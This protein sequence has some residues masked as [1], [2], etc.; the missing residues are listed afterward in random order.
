MAFISPESPNVYSNLNF[1][2]DLKKSSGLLLLTPPATTDTSPINK[3]YLL[4]NNFKYYNEHLNKQ[5]FNS[6]LLNCSINLLKMLYPQVHF[7]KVNMKFFIIE[8]IRRSKS[9]IQ[10]LQVCCFYLLKMKKLAND[11]LNQMKLPECP[12][13]LFLGM[14]IVA[15]KFIQDSNYSFKSWLK[16]CGCDNDNGSSKQMLDLALLRKTETD[17]LK[18]LGYETYINGLKYENWCNVLIIFGYDFIKYHNISKKQLIWETDDKVLRMKLAKWSKFLQNLN[19]NSL[20]FV[21]IN[22]SNY[23]FSQFGKKIF[24][25][26]DFQAKRIGSLFDSNKRK[27]DMNEDL[28]FCQLKKVKCL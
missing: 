22:F 4:P 15:S 18:L 1:E 21:K 7:Q 14:L 5:Q 19:I 27:L 6:I 10:V 17:C 3:D 23:Y 28:Y 25:D 26:S 24:Q 2:R 13:R 12:K 16:I 20:D 8:I 11:L 9:S